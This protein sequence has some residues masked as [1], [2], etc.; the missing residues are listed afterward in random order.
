M[1]APA[2]RFPPVDMTQHRKRRA[3]QNI[4]SVY[5]AT[6]DSVRQSGKEW[7]DRVHEATAKGIKGSSLNIHQGAALVAAV[8]PQMDWDK[9][10]IDALG[11]LRHLNKSQWGDVLKGDR[12]P[13]QGMS[14]SQ[15]PTSGLLKA[16]RIMHG[17]EDPD[18]V[19][20]RRTAPKTNSFMHN[21]AEPDKP[22]PVTI[23]GR[24]YDI[25]N[26]RMQG[27]EQA[28][29]IGSAATKS[30]KK[31]RYEH[32]E[33]AYRGAAKAIEIQHGDKL[34]PHQVQAATWE[35]GKHLERSAPTKSGLP[36]KQGPTRVG[37]PYV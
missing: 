4:A 1:P 35:G 28:R 32:F 29:G 8:S 2:P 14:V 3:V 9:R 6:P 11:E 30:G 13:L 24:A 12:S 15:S 33:D 25:A 16:H 34:L 20:D 37:Q 22:G 10:N 18:T 26:N 19:L 21:I 27:W 23:D 17:E 36:R 5:S 7:Y 31:T